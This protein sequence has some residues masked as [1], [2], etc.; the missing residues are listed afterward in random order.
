MTLTGSFPGSWQ[1]QLS[2]RNAIESSRAKSAAQRLLALEGAALVP[3]QP[4]RSERSRSA[5]HGGSPPRRR[6]GKPSSPSPL[7]V[8]NASAVRPYHP[9]PYETSKPPNQLSA[10]QHQI[11][12]SPGPD[13]C[14][15]SGGVAYGGN[16][17]QAVKFTKR[18]TGNPATTED[19]SGR[20]TPNP[21]ARAHIAYE[22]EVRSL[23]Q[24]ETYRST[25][26]TTTTTHSFIPVAAPRCQPPPKSGVSALLP[27]QWS[28]KWEREN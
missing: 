6:A 12:T 27:R 1:N 16:G 9:L 23:Q 13:L 14:S 3:P 25:V 15:G 11:A 18:P 4:R 2:A 10:Q 8:L 19:A 5:D 7:S 17:V 21:S 28:N 26:T 20:G 22:R 24:N